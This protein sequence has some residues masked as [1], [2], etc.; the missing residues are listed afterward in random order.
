MFD[1]CIQVRDAEALLK[2]KLFPRN[3]WMNVLNFNVLTSC[4]KDELHQWFIGLY[5]EHIIPA[6]VHRYTKVLQ[7]P[8]LVTVDK[9]GTSH[10]LLSGEAVARV[11]KRL[12]D[13]LQGVVWDTSTVTITPEYAAHFLEV[14]VKKTD[15]AKFTGDRIRFLMLSLPLAVRDLIAPEVFPWHMYSICMS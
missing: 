14:Y 10:P 15:G 11:F 13:R 4:P 12:A 9:E 5:G 3:A 6:I 1:I 7:R 2:H 8:D